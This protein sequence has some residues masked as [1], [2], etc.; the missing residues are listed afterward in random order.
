MK[1][2]LETT[3]TL[4]IG[5]ES[6]GDG[7]FTAQVGDYEVNNQWIVPYNH[8]TVEYAHIN[9]ECCNSVKSIKYVCKYV[10][11]GSDAAMFALQQQDE[12]TQY[13]LGPYYVL[14]N[15]IYFRGT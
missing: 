3:D 1:H 6:P 12:I 11:K 9:V 4:H 7:G 10:S 2:R 13:Q 5:E 15:Y 8:F 14:L